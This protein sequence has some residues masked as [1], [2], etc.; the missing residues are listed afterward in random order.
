LDEKCSIK[1]HQ[2]FN[3]FEMNILTQNNTDTLKACRYCP[4]CRQSC[5]SEFIS[6]RESDAPRGR[7]ILL[8]GIYMGG[9]EYDPS[10]V[11]SVYNCFLCGACKSWCSG[12]ELGGYDIP[13]LIKF[14][15]RE[16]VRKGIVPA[17][18]Q[19]IRD[20]LVAKDS[21]RDKDPT[22]SFTSSAVEK[23]ADV[24]YI[25]GEGVNHDHPE[26]AEAFIRVLEKCQ[27]SYTLL[28]DE[29]TSGKELDLLGYQDE[30]MEKARQMAGRVKATGCKKIV[31]SDPLVVDAFR[32]DYPAWGLQLGAEILHVSE[33][34]LGLVRV[35][36]LNLNPF[37]SKVTLADSEYLGRFNGIYEAQRE[38]IRASA[39]ENYTEMQ[40]H[41]EYQQ[42]AGEAAF[43]FNGLPF[44]RGAELGKKISVKAEECGATTIVILSATAK[45][46][47]TAT[48]GL[49]VMDIAEFA[50]TQVL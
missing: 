6:Y 3:E 45:S 42:S 26:I 22:L 31:V 48:T 49:K 25:T 24:L 38:V 46:N 40:W 29:P 1:E 14:A 5:P 47:I 10:T 15:R 4:M 20:S 33:Y 34:I 12:H 21:M 36:V 27:I 17:G 32:N 44:D 19:A 8:H 28:K 35:G 30:A 39:G 43:T 13:E 37:R 2:Q 50:A 9:R 11:L 7:A 16:I 23:A 18:V 41:H